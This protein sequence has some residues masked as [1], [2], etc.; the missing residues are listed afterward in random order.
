MR[1]QSHFFSKQNPKPPMKFYCTSLTLIALAAL[2]GFSAQAQELESTTPVAAKTNGEAWWNGNCK[3]IDDDIAKMEGNID[4]AFVGDSITARWRGNENWTKHWGNYRAVNMGI[5]GDQT[6]HVLWRLQN[7]DLDG[8]K[9]K[10]FVVMIGTNN[11]W[12]KTSEPAHAAAGVKAVLDLIKSKHPESKILLMSVLP[13]GEKPNPGRDKRKEVNA[14]ISK[15]AGG[16]VE[17][18]DI[19]D[20]YLNAEGMISKDTMHDFLHLAPGGYDIWADAISAKVKAIV[21]EKK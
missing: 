20:K 10:L 3:R 6:Q 1:F 8:Y 2:A 16:N 11:M 5:G 13:T 15:F 21:G 7:G 14:L 9:C 12:G 4:V 19:W 18:V 17:Y